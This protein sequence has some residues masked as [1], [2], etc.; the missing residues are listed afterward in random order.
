MITKYRHPSFCNRELIPSK[1][2]SPRGTYTDRPCVITAR[3]AE[4]SESNNN[5]SFNN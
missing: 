2:P 3:S 4:G 1:H 5:D